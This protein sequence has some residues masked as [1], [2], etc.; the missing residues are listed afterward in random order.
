M[1]AIAAWQGKA[2]PSDAAA[3]GLKGSIVGDKPQADVVVQL[4]SA[5]DSSLVKTEFTDEKGIFVFSAIPGGNYF[6]Q[7]SLLGY[8]PYTSDVIALNGDK[9]LGPF[10]L[11]KADVELKEVVVA[12]RKPYIEHDHGKVVL[13]VESSITAAG[14]SLFEIIEKAPGVAV[15]NNDNIKLKGKS[16]LVVQIDGK[17]TPMT[18]T[19]LANFLRGIPASAVEKIEFIN[20]PSARYDAA[21][22][23]IINVKLKKDT[24]LG[25]NGSITA[26]YGQGVY[27]KTNA[28]FTLNHREKKI[29]VFGNYNY[30]YRESFNDLKLSRSFYQDGAYTGS[31]QQKNYLVFPI[32][33]H[34]ARAGFDYF[35]NPKN[36][37]GVVVNG[38]DNR[39]NPEGHN[40]SD[41][42][43][44]Q[45][46]LASRF[47]TTSKSKDKLQN[48]SANMNYKHTFDSTGTELTVDLDYARFG[49][50][51]R[52]LFT[53]RYLN[54]DNTEYASPYLLYGN[55]SGS[56]DIYSIKS[57]FSKPL[58]KNAKIEAGIK[59]SYVIADND[60]RF[61][62]RSQGSD[63]YDST[64]SNHFIYQENI[65]AAYVN[66]SK[67]WKNWST[68][69]G[70]RCE[71]THV[72]GT[73]VVYNSRFDTNYVQL[74]PSAFVSYK[75]S[76]KHSMELSYSRR[77]QR[78]S[79]DQLNPFKFFLDPTTY[80]EG[81]PYLKPQTTHFVDLSYVLNQ[82]IYVTLEYNRT[83]NNITEVLAPSPIQQNVTVQTNKNLH[84][85]DMY[86][87]SISAP[88]E[89]TKWWYST[90]D[91]SSYYAGYT[92]NIANTQISN[93]GNVTFNINTVNTFNIGK[94]W[95]AELSANYRARE[96]YAY[97]IIKPIGFVSAGAQKKLFGGKGLV[98]LNISDIFFTNKIRASTAFVNYKESFIVT[99]ETRVATL[100][101][102]YKF[103]KNSVAPSRRRSGGAD[104]LKQR[105]G[106]NGTG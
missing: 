66:L 46:I 102:T 74:F 72:T 86:I 50:L 101:F 83:A 38:V 29:N 13:N 80:R 77:I 51:T 1:L 18:G 85:V 27:P 103:G 23:A 26:G 30:S 16:G 39:Y 3:Y 69:L 98:K 91:F 62:N 24:R 63:V 76:E 17:P 56:L 42:L 40:R 47:E 65:N 92:G 54:L 4:L 71:H 82:K 88:V 96:I 41:V 19:D 31:Y 94:T 25:T 105:V 58:K 43:N 67:D 106:N 55:L 15:D 48:Y 61:Y 59:S 33:T 52:Q 84:Q 73:Q 78:P 36:T 11:S 2:Q 45:G 81:N 99:R 53:T 70:L 93:R 60:L 35:I 57:D 28:G 22:S 6:I 20:N 75:I 95:S 97:D 21:G 104:D 14:S 64:K 100:S 79:Y 7:T 49:N 89:V 44:S 8:K 32:N 10:S 90:N 68:Q 12:A 37:F 9:S 5:K 87:L 34:V